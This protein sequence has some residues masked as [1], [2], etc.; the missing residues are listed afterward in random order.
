MSSKE[1]RKLALKKIINGSDMALI[2][3]VY[4][5]TAVLFV[6]L[7]EMLIYILVKMAGIEDY[8]PLDISYYLRSRPALILLIVR[9]SGYVTLFSALLFLVCRSFISFTAETESKGISKF[10]TGHVG[11]LL[12]PSLRNNARLLLLKI[13]VATPLTVS[14][15][16]IVHYARL[17]ERGGVSMAGLLLFMVSI[18]F[19]IVWIGVLIRYYISLSLVPYIIDLNP[20]AN[21]FDACDLSVKLMDGKH[22]YA[23]GFMFSLLPVLLPCLLVYPTF[24]VYPYILECQLLFAKEIM[25]DYWQDKIPAM[26]RRWQ[27]QFGKADKNK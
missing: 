24:I 1:I 9:C 10:L 6:T 23:L 15:Y 5:F 17:G 16:G 27:K 26:A 12:L 13:L 20:R 19:T 18:G 21:F 8:H 2:S 3:T 25:G 4:F 11:K 7:S 22:M 14:V